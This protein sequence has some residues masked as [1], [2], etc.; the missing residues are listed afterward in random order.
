MI[1]KGN[2]R[3]VRFDANTS[4]LI[5]GVPVEGGWVPRLSTFVKTKGAWRLVGHANFSVPAATL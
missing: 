1:N 4:Q 3:V 2:T 5:N